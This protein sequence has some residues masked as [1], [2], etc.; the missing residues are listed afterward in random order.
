MLT[1]WHNRNT[2]H[3]AAGK[4]LQ[5]QLVTTLQEERNYYWS[6]HFSKYE[7]CPITE[8]WPA[9]SSPT[10]NTKPEC[11]FMA[12][13][14]WMF[15]C[16][17]ASLGTHKPETMQILTAFFLFSFFLSLRALA[18]SNSWHS[19]TCLIPFLLY[20]WGFTCM[21]C[22]YWGL[23]SL[24]VLN[25]WNQQQIYGNA[26]SPAV[27]AETPAKGLAHS[28]HKVLSF[29]VITGSSWFM[30]CGDQKTSHKSNRGRR[31]PFEVFTT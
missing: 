29:T 31:G 20:L 11:F 5:Y 7:K 17:S 25:N 30:Q 12:S 26:I 13:E 21:D 18:T 15:H 1:N 10:W 14:T 8:S 23:V 3:A 22:K 19:S 4:V 9:G 16:L 2:R 6:Q 24:T 27:T 28:C